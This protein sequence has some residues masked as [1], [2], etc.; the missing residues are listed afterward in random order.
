[1]I[2]LD[3]IAPETPP[4]HTQKSQ[5][6]P[7]R[8]MKI[9]LAVFANLLAFAFLPWQAASLFSLAT[10]TFFLWPRSQSK[11]TIIPSLVNKRP[12]LYQQEPSD[13]FNNL[14]R[15][16]VVLRD[17]RGSKIPVRAFSQ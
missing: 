2:H 1:M 7:N 15:S 14:C 9:A 6:R 3:T 4:H 12:L 13:V 16:T 10:L 8:V 17:K 5:P 11:E